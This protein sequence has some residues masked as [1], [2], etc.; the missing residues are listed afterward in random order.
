VTW[1]L[2]PVEY[3]R[4]RC[5]AGPAQESR[6]KQAAEAAVSAPRGREPDAVHE[7]DLG[8]EWGKL[9]LQFFD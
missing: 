6:G 8:A 1:K 7:H 9:F 5:G 4:S 2:V 3:D